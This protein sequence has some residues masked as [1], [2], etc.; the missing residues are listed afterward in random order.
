MKCR[1]CHKEEIETRNKRKWCLRCLKAKDTVEKKIYQKRL[2][3]AS[4]ILK[5]FVPLKH[6]QTPITLE[7]I[8]NW[9]IEFDLKKTV[10][11]QYFE[12]LFQL[13]K[14]LEKEQ[15]EL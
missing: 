2:A 9:V 14:K 11:I 10:H 6:I 5:A 1:R 4:Y 15:E 3:I 8:H 7:V 12:Y 13:Q